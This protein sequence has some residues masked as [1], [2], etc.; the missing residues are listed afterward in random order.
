MK[1]MTAV[2]C[3]LS[4]LLALA[5]CSSGANRPEQRIA[6][7]WESDVGATEFQT[8]E[9]IP[10]SDNPQRGQVN[11]R[12]LGNEISGDYEI[13]SGEE[14]HRLIITY[15]LMMFPTTREF[16]FALEDDTLVLHEGVA[17]VIYHRVAEGT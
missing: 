4:L 10:N 14:Q 12:I 7:R 11:L 3:A 9:F 1:K 13:A 17:G 2:L 5:A 16:T 6:G 8:M 15:T